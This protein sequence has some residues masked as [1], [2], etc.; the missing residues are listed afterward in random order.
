MKVERFRNVYLSPSY[1]TQVALFKPTIR[2]AAGYE[3]NSTALS[4]SYEANSRSLRQTSRTRNYPPL[5]EPEGRLPVHKSSPLDPTP[6]HVTQSTS[7]NPIFN[8]HSSSIL[9]LTSRSLH[10][11]IPFKFSDQNWVLHCL[12]FK[13][14]LHA[15]P[16]HSVLLHLI[17]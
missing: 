1:N 5:V 4:L 9:L 6:S 12:S 10:W 2:A 15:R 11:S 8:I 16:S 17:A 3:T 14:V 13:C 7:S